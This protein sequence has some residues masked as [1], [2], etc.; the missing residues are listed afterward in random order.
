MHLQPVATGGNLELLAVGNLAVAAN[1]GGDVRMTSYGSIVGA[2]SADGDILWLGS[3]G[4]LC[5]DFT[6][7]G[8]IDEIVSYAGIMANISATNI[9]HIRAWGDIGSTAHAITASDTIYEI[10]SGGEITTTISA[11]NIGTLAEYNRTKFVDRPVAPSLPIGELRAKTA[12]AY[13]SLMKMGEDFDAAATELVEMQ[14]AARAGIEKS[15]AQTEE[16]LAE[17]KTEGEAR[18]ADLGKQVALAE[19]KA[20]Q[21]T[22]RQFEIA[23]V[24]AEAAQR[25][26]VAAVDRLSDQ[27]DRKFKETEGSLEA[28]KEA[29]EQEVAYLTARKDQILVYRGE[30]QYAAGKTRDSLLATA[31][32]TF[33]GLFYGQMKEFSL[34]FVQDRLRGVAIV[35]AFIP[36]YGWLVSSITGAADGAISYYRGDRVGGLIEIGLSAIP[37]VGRFGKIAKVTSS[38]GGRVGGSLAVSGTAKLMRLPS[39]EP[40]LAARGALGAFDAITGKLTVL[41]GLSWAKQAEVL[42]HESV[43]RWFY[44]KGGFLVGARRRLDARAY[45]NSAF[46]MATEETIAQTYATGSLRQGLAHAFSGAYSTSHGGVVTAKRYITEAVGGV[47][48]IVGSWCGALGFG[49]WLWGGE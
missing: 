45:S 43:H 22:D 37:L 24:A 19:I 49:E 36:G 7:A 44:P 39:Y 15:L 5:G 41:P 17:L 12:D 2:V 10:Y 4:T 32:P 29:V 30:E 21:Q 42:C 16:R 27:A 11:P 8:D 3:M 20:Q 33:A 35:S 6:A 31:E 1:V 48:V 25:S 9:D 47:T 38:T 13:A 18:V 28:G 23:Q 14:S 34:D 26:T 46:F 40:M